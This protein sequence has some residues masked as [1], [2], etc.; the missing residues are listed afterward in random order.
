VLALEDD[1]LSGFGAAGWL[2]SKSNEVISV[3]V[4]RQIGQLKIASGLERTM[5][6]ASSKSSG[7]IADPC[8]RDP[9]VGTPRPG[10]W[11]IGKLESSGASGD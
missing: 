11:W 6:V 4:N 9:D 3:V 8:G 7:G 2:H 5:V 1:E 10:R